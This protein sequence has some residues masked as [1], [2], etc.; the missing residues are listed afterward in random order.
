MRQP[1]PDAIEVL[2]MLSPAQYDQ[3]GD[4]LQKVRRQLGLPA[5]TSNTSLIIEAVGR[6]ARAEGEIRVHDEHQPP[7]TRQRR[8]PSAF[9]H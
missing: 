4:D 5:G 2:L 8:S 3:M 9:R 1:R 7:S 6:Q